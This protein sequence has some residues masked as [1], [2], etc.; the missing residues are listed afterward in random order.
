[1]L[2]L[3]CWDS[4]NLIVLSFLA[5]LSYYFGYSGSYSA[6]YLLINI[7]FAIEISRLVSVYIFKIKR[8]AEI[9]PT[10]PPI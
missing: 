10:K 8:T 6:V 1:M 3:L 5:W 9:A 4:Y 2:N 7:L